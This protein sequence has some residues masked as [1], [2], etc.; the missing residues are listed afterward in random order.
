MIEKSYLEKLEEHKG[1]IYKMVN[2]YADNDEDRKDLYQEIISQS[3]S[4][5]PR[6]KGEAKFSTWLYKIS[7]NVSLSFLSKQKKLTQIRDHDEFNSYFEP[8]ELSER[9]DWLYRCIKQLSEIDR[10]IIMLHL[11]GF[12]NTEI[13]EMTGISRNSTNVKLHRIKQQ[14][15]TLLT[16]K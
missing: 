12:T 15:T 4:A 13:S 11:D 3:W 14:L 5:Y 1:I 8:P 7:L 2:L 10:G 9:A 16:G 6:F